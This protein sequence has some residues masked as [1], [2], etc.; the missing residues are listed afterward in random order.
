MPAL[1]A[2]AMGLWGAGRLSLWRDEAITSEIA[3]RSVPDILRCARH[4]DAVH[5][6]YYLFM[7]GVVQV[8]GTGELALRLPSIAA[9][10]ATAA[11]VTVLGRR[12][13]SGAA[14]LVAGVICAGA[15]F[16]SHYAHEA[17]SYSLVAALTVWLTVLLV[18]LAE[19][20]SPRRYAAYGAGIALLGLVHLFALLILPAHLVTLLM[21]R[22]TRTMLRRWSA[23]SAGALVA[24]SPLIALAATQRNALDWLTRPGWRDVRFLAES[25]TGPRIVAYVLGA[26]MAVGLATAR[27]RGPIGVQALA[28]PW[29][30][31]PAAV[32]LLASQFHPVF[33]GRYVIGSLPAMALLAAAGLARLPYRAW[34]VPLVAMAVLV[35]PLHVE[36]RRPE[37]WWDDLRG[38]AAIVEREARPGDAIVFVTADRR[39]I[40]E[41]YPDAFRGLHDVTL[42]RTPAQAGN[43]GGTEFA[44]AEID[45]RVAGAAATRVWLLEGPWRMPSLAPRDRAKVDVLQRHFRQAGA[46]RVRGITLSL[47][48]REKVRP[49][50]Q[51]PR[52]GG[53]SSP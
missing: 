21:T 26:A 13:V 24:V 28:V 3:R 46:W 17:R 8:F 18:D 39:S 41:A 2:L 4:I 22:R 49:P 37:N 12:I 50:M 42:R 10:A 40:A 9:L 1:L 34:V 30:L 51:H 36:Q 29:L 11:G 52:P 27:R 32:L 44:P 45:R 31:L 20:G 16:A 6:A 5:A 38:A 14:G 7:H 35:A 15:P 19:R 25:F 53:V 48:Q 47:F 43:F 23:A 33:T